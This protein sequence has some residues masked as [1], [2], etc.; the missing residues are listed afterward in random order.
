M[1]GGRVGQMKLRAV[2]QHETDR[3]PM[4]NAECGQSGGDLPYPIGVLAPGQDHGVAGRAD[5]HRVRLEGCGLLK[6][7]WQR[8]YQCPAWVPNHRWIAIGHFLSAPSTTRLTGVASRFRI[9]T[10]ESPVASVITES[11][12]FLAPGVGSFVLIAGAPG[13][14]PLGVLDAD[15]ESGSDQRLQYLLAVC[16]TAGFEG[17]PHLDFIQRQFACGTDMHHVKNAG[18]G[19]A[20]HG[21]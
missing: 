18:A 3:V 15:D 1:H 21:E 8:G 13:A 7:L 6:G 16:C 20:D 14:R 4:L 9:P 12:A 5:G 19:R 11:F 17:K 2:T 10:G